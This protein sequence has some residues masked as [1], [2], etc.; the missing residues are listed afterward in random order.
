[1]RLCRRYRTFILLLIF[2]GTA[3]GVSSAD[4][5]LTNPLPNTIDQIRE[6]VVGI[7]TLRPHKSQGKGS[8]ISFLGTGFVVGD[9]QQVVTNLHVL[10]E[11][12]DKESGEVLAIFVGR[13]EA[14][15]ATPVAVKA[16]DTLHDLVL[17][18]LEAE[19]L[20]PLKLGKDDYVREG[21]ALAFTG[22]PIGVVLGLYP[23]THRAT[24][25]AVTPYVVP[26]H[27]TATLTAEQVKRLRH[28]FD[29]YQL[30][31]IAYPGS[32]GSPLYDIRTGT[33]LG[34]LNSIFV[35]ESK[36]QVLRDPSGIAYAIPIR[37]VNKLISDHP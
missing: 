18:Q 34:V 6:S 15:K 16:V 8:P 10:P 27:S 5:A 1:M 30:D 13:G 19:A 32:S 24:V 22:F 14:A 33:V 12:V 20:K 29:V 4:S 35:K 25:S 2:S 37:H 11:S 26:A 17:L 36:E 28:P 3:A 21:S 7:G 23:V 9:G 31:A